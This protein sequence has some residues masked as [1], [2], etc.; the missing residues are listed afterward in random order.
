MKAQIKKFFRQWYITRILKFSAFSISYGISLLLFFF[1]FMA[2]LAQ[3]NGYIP[4]AVLVTI[5]MFGEKWVELVVIIILIPFLAYGLKLE[6][7]DL[8]RYRRGVY[9]ARVQRVKKKKVERL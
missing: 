8:R 9:R 6:Y 5:N 7:Q 2:F 4:D 3:Y 1:W